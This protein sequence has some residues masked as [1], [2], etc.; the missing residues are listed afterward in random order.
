MCRVVAAPAVGRAAVGDCRSAMSDGRSTTDPCGGRRGAE[1]RMACRCI[2]VRFRC[3]SATRVSPTTPFM[4]AG[5]TIRSPRTPIA[6]SDDRESG[7]GG[8]NAAAGAGCGG[9]KVVAIAASPASS[10]ESRKPSM[11]L[12]TCSLKAVAVILRRMTIVQA[13]R[14]GGCITRVRRTAID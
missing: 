11:V 2:S 7:A 10:S 6:D 3:I 5:R 8:G 1:E 9:A 13:A 14:Q 12:C 4:F